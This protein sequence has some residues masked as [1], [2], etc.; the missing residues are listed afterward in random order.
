MM[1][2]CEN[3]SQTAAS[4]E[5]PEISRNTAAPIPLGF[6]AGWES[7]SNSIYTKANSTGGVSTTQAGVFPPFLHADSYSI[8]Q[9][10]ASTSATESF[11]GDSNLPVDVGTHNDSQFRSELKAD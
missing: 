6:H 1:I 10:G 3:R 4:D 9:G 2:T 8:S 7:S 5:L 11:A